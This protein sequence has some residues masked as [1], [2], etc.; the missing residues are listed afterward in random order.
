MT[1]AKFIGSKNRH[2]L[3]LSSTFGRRE[4]RLQEILWDQLVRAFPEKK[5]RMEYMK[6]LTKGL[7]EAY[8]RKEKEDEEN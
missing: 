4:K 8:D 5:A 3:L 6:M 1:R 2:K 7:E